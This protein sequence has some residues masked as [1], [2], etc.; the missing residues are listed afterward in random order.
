MSIARSIALAVGLG[1]LG[2]VTRASA[3]TRQPWSIQGSALYTA[4]DLGKPAGVVGAAGIEAQLRRT[5]ARW[6]IGGGVQYSKH[7]SG[8]DALTLTGFFIEP[9]LVFAVGSGELSP[10]LAGRLAYLHGSL[11]AG[12]FGGEGSAGGTAF[13]AGAGLIY[14]LTHRVNLDIGGALLRQSL[15]NIQLDGPSRALIG[16]PS[17]FGYVVKAGFSVGL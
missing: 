1:S 14:D 17:F 9:R 8:P 2:V 13:G 7:S 4:Q 11:S 5:L 15:N 10:Y 6:S 16:F 12:G 3:Q